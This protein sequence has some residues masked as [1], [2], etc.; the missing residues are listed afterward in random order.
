[1]ETINELIDV[2]LELLSKANNNSMFYEEFLDLEAS[3]YQKSIRDKE[4]LIRNLTS[5]NLRLGN[6]DIRL[7]WYL[8]IVG[9]VIGFITKYFISQ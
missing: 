7:R 4:E 3:E 6:W 5:Y 2:N 9:F 8:A 1:M